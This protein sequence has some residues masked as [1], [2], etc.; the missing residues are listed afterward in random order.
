MILVLVS[1]VSAEGD[2]VE[3]G[4]G[5]PRRASVPSKEYMRFPPGNRIYSRRLASAHRLRVAEQIP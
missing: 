2:V 1:E 5:F 3:G 4:G